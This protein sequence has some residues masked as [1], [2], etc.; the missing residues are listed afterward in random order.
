MA[1]AWTDQRMENI[2][3]NLLRS[4]VAL[5]AGL[6]VVGAAAFL[7]RHGGEVPSWHV[8]R[9]EPSDLSSVG[10]VLRGAATLRGREIIQLGLLV[11]IATPVARVAFAVFGF[12]NEGDRKYV[13]VTLIVLSLL[14]CSLGIGHI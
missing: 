9:G 10:G 6:V 14:L 13:V 3:G 4:G 2:I 7:A 5:A 12:A 8:F 11:L 1:N